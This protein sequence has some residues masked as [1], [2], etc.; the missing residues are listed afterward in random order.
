MTVKGKAFKFALLLLIVAT[1]IF[2][3]IQS[4]LPPEKSSAESDA[5]GGVIGEIIPPDT[6]PGAFIQIN[7]RKIAHFT[8]F[9]FL[10]AEIALYVVLFMRQKICVWLSYPVALIIALFDESIQILSDRG[11]SV[12]DVWIDFFG[13]FTSACVTYAIIFT[14][15]HF[16]MR[17]K[18]EDLTK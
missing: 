7:L 9:F 3:F 10:G 16:L 17:K 18:N 6:K 14:V 12:T 2:I 15:K 5:V 4:I 11:P 13:F 1:V 8:E